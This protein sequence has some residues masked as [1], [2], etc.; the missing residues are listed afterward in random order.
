MVFWVVKRIQDDIRASARIKLNDKSCA[1]GRYQVFNATYRAILLQRPNESL[2][3]L[4][5]Q[6]SS[7]NAFEILPTFRLTFVATY[8]IVRRHLPVYPEK[9]AS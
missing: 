9:A 7:V 5:G 1:P 8:S 2:R 3:T 4:Q 6:S